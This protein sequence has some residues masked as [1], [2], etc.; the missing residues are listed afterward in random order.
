MA[1]YHV[2]KCTV[3]GV[4]IISYCYEILFTKFEKSEGLQQEWQNLLSFV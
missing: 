1:Q 2:K 4:F 3:Q